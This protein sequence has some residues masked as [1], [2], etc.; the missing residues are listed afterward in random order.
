MRCFQYPNR[1]IALSGLVA[2]LSLAGCGSDDDQAQLEAAQKSLVAASQAVSDA[3]AVVEEREAQAEAADEEL[4]VAKREL[5]QAE[6]E[7]GKIETSID[8]RATDTVLFRII[9]RALLEDEDLEK[10]AIAAQVE[11]GVVYLRGRV[12]DAELQQRA[13]DIA[14]DA[15]GVIGVESSIAVDTP[16]VATPPPTQ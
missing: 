15:P 11:D 8:A 7:L 4:Q 5:R 16:A 10:F 14:G 13:V 6:I 12:P 3:R 2:V 1:L 9:Q